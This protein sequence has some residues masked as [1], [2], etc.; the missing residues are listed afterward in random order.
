ME[1]EE[2]EE[3]EEAVGPLTQGQAGLLVD[4]LELL[5]PEIIS[6]CPDIQLKVSHS[7]CHGSDKLGL[8]A[9]ASAINFDQLLMGKCAISVQRT[10][11][12]SS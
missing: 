11:H 7:V 6:S 10:T 4:W 5:D 8:S 3:E 12:A 9:H 2:G 1:V